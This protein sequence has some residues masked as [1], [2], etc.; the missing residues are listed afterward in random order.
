MVPAYAQPQNSPG[1]DLSSPSISQSCCEEEVG[2]GRATSCAA[3]LSTTEEGQGVRRVLFGCFLPAHLE[4]LKAAS[5]EPPKKH[6]ALSQI[7]HGEEVSI[8][9]SVAVHKLSTVG[10]EHTRGLK[11]RET[12]PDGQTI[13]VLST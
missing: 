7:E 3:T 9:F 6:R 1:E 12:K 10:S 5:K 11:T 2:A 4:N 13:A 8:I